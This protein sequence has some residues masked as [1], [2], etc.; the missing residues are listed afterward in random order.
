MGG[1]RISS[2]TAQH[3]GPSLFYLYD[4]SCCP[5]IGTPWALL[6]RPIAYTSTI[7]YL[8]SISRIYPMQAAMVL[9]TLEAGPNEKNM[10][11][12]VLC[13]LLVI[14]FLEGAWSAFAYQEGEPP[15]RA[16]ASE[17]TNMVTNRTIDSID[18]CDFASGLHFLH[19]L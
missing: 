11:V 6:K 1:S 10:Q 14:S 3:R 12:W 13:T 5:N 4:L 8:Q 17:R 19:L 18:A 7:A 2:G 9:F 15:Q 16:T